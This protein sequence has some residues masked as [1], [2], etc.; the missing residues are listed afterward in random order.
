LEYSY[1]A[2]I[3]AAGFAEPN[4]LRRF[5]YFSGSANEATRRAAASFEA[6]TIE[7]AT[8]KL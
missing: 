8:S 7:I 3:K 4:L 1:I 5:D 6:H 2:L